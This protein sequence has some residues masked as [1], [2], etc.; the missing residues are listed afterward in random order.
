LISRAQGR[1]KKC[2]SGALTLGGGKS[3]CIKENI[4]ATSKKAIGVLMCTKVK[5]LKCKL[6]K[7]IIDTMVPTKDGRYFIS[8]R[9]QRLKLR[10]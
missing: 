3:L 10:D 4:S 1:Q 9:R 5:M 6:F 2:K 8:I 7:F